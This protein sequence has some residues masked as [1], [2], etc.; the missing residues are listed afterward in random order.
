MSDYYKEFRMMR[1]NKFPQTLALFALILTLS[2]VSFAKGNG[3][4][5]PNIKISNFGQMDEQF[6]RGARPK[7]KDYP[8]L[9][10]LGIKTIIDLTDNSRSY[11]QPA[12]EAA[13][14][15]YVNVPLVDKS[16]PTADQVNAFLKV[17]N[18][19]ATG[20][21][22]VHCAGG[23]HRT[24]I[25]AAVYRF[26]HDHWNFDQAY[27]EMLKYDFY[28]SN[29]HGKQLDFIQDYWQQFQASHATVASTTG[30]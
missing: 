24:G 5:F 18:D 4:N 14:L 11:E 17:V 1:L 15:R 7:D 6:Y 2:V 8:A 3:S 22:F 13:G 19:P 25:M 27:A 26:N 12:V 9:A 29:G 20:K 28:T 21:F 30:R 16:Y 23:R 10:A